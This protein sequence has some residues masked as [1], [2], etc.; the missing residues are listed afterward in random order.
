[1]RNARDLVR[2]YEKLKVTH[3]LM[4]MDFYRSVQ[5]DQTPLARL[6][7][8]AIRVGR[9]RIVAQVPGYLLFEIEKGE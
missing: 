7:R 6:L 9:L 1:M 4:T 3:V 8:E 5:Q 2:A